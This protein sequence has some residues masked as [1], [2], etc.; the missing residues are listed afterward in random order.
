MQ[1]INAAL[2]L[3]GLHFELLS[4]GRMQ[5]FVDFIADY[6]F[7]D[8]PLGKSLGVVA[9]DSLKEIMKVRFSEYLS[10]ILIDESSDEIIGIRTAHTLPRSWQLNTDEIKDKNKITLLK[11]YSQKHNEKNVFKRFCVNVAIQFVN[12]FV[13]PDFRERGLGCKLTEAALMFFSQFAIEMPC[14]TGVGTSGHAQRIFE[15]I[16][17]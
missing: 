11:F 1:D 4:E 2:P 5:T 17:V 3:D 12:L 15:K 7:P 9:D 13:R 8:M 16:W 6:F 10:L 14:I